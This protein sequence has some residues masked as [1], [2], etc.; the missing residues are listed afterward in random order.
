MNE[1]ELSRLF[2]LTE[3]IAADPQ[4]LDEFISTAK[5]DTNPF[6]SLTKPTAELEQAI[7]ALHQALRD[8]AGA[9]GG[10]LSEPLLRE[11]AKNLAEQPSQPAKLAA[12]ALL[13]A[14]KRQS[15]PARRAAP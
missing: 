9:H 2:L 15:V 5:G 8:Q 13:S 7:A 11:A 12:H 6:I 3:A 14:L 4:R 10:D 1:F